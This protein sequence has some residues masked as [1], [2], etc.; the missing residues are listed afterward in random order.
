MTRGVVMQFENYRTNVVG[1][2][3]NTHYPAD[4]FIRRNK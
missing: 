4:E 1:A 3:N 2:R